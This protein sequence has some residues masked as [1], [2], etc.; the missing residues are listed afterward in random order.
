MVCLSRVCVGKQCH[1]QLCTPCIVQLTE[2][3]LSEGTVLTVTV[4]N[5]S[6]LLCNDVCMLDLTFT[7]EGGA[8]EVTV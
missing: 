4:A 3:Q 2:T 6:K 5:G 7:V 1:A 8:R